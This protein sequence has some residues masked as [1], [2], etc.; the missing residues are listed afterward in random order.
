MGLNE[1]IIAARRF[2]V[3]HCGMSS[4][5]S[6]SITELASEFGLRDDPATYREIDETDARE[7]VQRLLHRDQAYEVQIMPEEEA[8]RLTREF[9]AQFGPESRYFTNNWC[10]ATKATFDEG[11]LVMG[12][13]RYGCFWVEDED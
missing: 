8:A 6:P 9:F 11:V 2:G 7:C 5:P 10:S 12:P 1:Q 3:V 4:Q 13:R